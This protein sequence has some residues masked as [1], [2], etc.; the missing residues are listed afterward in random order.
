MLG[1][2]AAPK[3]ANPRVTSFVGPRAIGLGVVVAFRD[4]FSR[5]K[6]EILRALRQ[7]GSVD[8]VA[9]A[10]RRLGDTV[11]IQ[12]NYAQ[13]CVKRAQER[14]VPEALDAV[15]K[16]IEEEIKRAKPQDFRFEDKSA[17]LFALHLTSRFTPTTESNAA[18][19]LF[20]MVDPRSGLI[21]LEVAVDRAGLSQS[22]L[23]EQF[24]R[25]AKPKARIVTWRGK[26]GA[27]VTTKTGRKVFIEEKK[28]RWFRN[29]TFVGGT[30]VLG[31]TAGAASLGLVAATN[32]SSLLL[33]KAGKRANSLRLLRV[34]SFL[35]RIAGRIEK[36]SIIVG[37]AGCGVLLAGLLGRY[38]IA[39]SAPR[40][41]KRRR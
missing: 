20:D 39:K 12:A 9:Q 18:F 10:Y 2:V 25:A 5:H 40:R 26:R 28:I 34:A 17:K 16:R 4:I 14:S 35:E 11:W 22:K 27:W 3:N 33:E 30:G 19:T 29:W 1:I 36:T 38:L 31:A 21:F 7:S 13:Y 15:F 23:F 6:E 24:K 32:L 8:K 41:R 37:L